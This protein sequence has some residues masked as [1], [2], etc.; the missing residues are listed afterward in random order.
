MKKLLV[1]SP[2]PDDETLAAG[3]LISS[4]VH[5]GAH[6]YVVA[7]TDGEN[8]Y[9]VDASGLAAMRRLEQAA[10]LAR[11]GVRPGNISRLKLIDSGLSA[12]EDEIVSS[13]VPM[14]CSDTHILAPW[15]GDFHPDHEACGRAAERIADAVGASLTFY[16]FWTWHRGVPSLLDG[17]HLCS[18][19]LDQDLRK[20]KE[21][22]LDEYSSQLHHSSGEPILPDHLLWPARRSSEIFLPV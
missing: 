4:Q 15:T 8:A 5:M 20:A 18:F 16:F 1:I 12:Q 6:V 21:E 14:V 17:Y 10:A 7:V 13:I 2:H 19:P 22:A 9:D 3:G 11:L